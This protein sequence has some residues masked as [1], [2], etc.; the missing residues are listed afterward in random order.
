MKYTF[1]ESHRC[2]KVAHF[3]LEI[4]VKPILIFLA[5][6]SL[7]AC[8]AGPPMVA[9]FNGD[10]VEIEQDTSMGPAD[11]SDPA[12]IAEAQRIC[13][14]AGRRAEYASTRSRMTGQYTS[15]ATHLFLCLGR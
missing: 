6:A 9:G 1:D 8:V 13:K 5:A 7:S 14:T 4:E 12:V 11:A 2:V 10:S 3:P 15:A